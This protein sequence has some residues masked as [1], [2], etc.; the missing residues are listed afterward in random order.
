MSS[1]L[2][3]TVA[4]LQLQLIS[5]RLNLTVGF[6]LLISGIVGN[7][8]N[9][10][11]F[12]NSGNYK[13]NACSLYVIVRSFFDLIV[14]GFGL[15]TR[16]LSY[17]FQIDLTNIS[18]IWCKL[19][20]ALI[21]ATCLVSLT[22]ICLQSIDAYLSSSRHVAYRRMSNVRI[23]RYLIAG[24][25]CIWIL[26][27]VPYVY[28]QDLVDVAGI[29]VCLST[30]ANYA[31]YHNYFVI[32]GLWTIIPITIIIVFGFLSYIHLRERH[33]L[34]DLTRQMIN[35]TLFQS[36]S[37]FIFQVPSEIAVA[38]FL[39]T[40]NVNVNAYYRARNQLIQLFL[41]NYG[42]GTY[43]TLPLHQKRHFNENAWKVRKTQIFQDLLYPNIFI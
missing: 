42:Y 8:L 36:A 27:E 37:V 29:L 3:D 16:I 24:S 31:W 11:V 13:N 12:L 5:Q 18:R 9:I 43:V 2:T 15:G 34:L 1:N 38:Y 14:V 40:A 4:I 33:A 20:V 28:F 17:N 32:I 25:I 41:S 19:R 6:I 30:N 39:A 21:Y 7:L 10:F 35:M 23:A 22:C 26:H